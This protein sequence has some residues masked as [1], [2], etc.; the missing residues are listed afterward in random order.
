MPSEESRDIIQFI[1]DDGRANLTF[2]SKPT[3]G[4]SLGGSLLTTWMSRSR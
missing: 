3:H 4:F 2:E 1:D